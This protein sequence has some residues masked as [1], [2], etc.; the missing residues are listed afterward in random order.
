MIGS[1]AL[2]S[3]LIVFLIVPVIA[4]LQYY[5]PKQYSTAMNVFW[6]IVAIITW[7][8]IPVILFVRHKNTIL[9]Y[10]FWISLIVFVVSSNIWLLANLN[11]VIE[12]MQK[13][14]NMKLYS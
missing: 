8:I 1:L 7:P 5:S 14:S 9:N 10:V 12:I 4:L 13:Y 6:V 11:F 2:V 3:G